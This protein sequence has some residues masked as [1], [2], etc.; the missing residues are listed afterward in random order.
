[1]GS[2]N[3]ERSNKSSTLFCQKKPYFLQF[4]I[5]TRLI[6]IK[7]LRR[8]GHSS[9]LLKFCYDCQQ[10]PGGATA[11][12]RSTSKYNKVH[13]Y[14]HQLKKQAVTILT[15]KNTFLL[16]FSKNYYSRKRKNC[17]QFILF[18][19]F[20]IVSFYEQVNYILCCIYELAI[21]D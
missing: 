17:L 3:N 5:C 18:G 12:Y 16:I 4:S 13:V 11:S 9:K 2:P 14:K 7:Q 21:F 8:S 20:Y 19:F 1:M 15:K 6:N 10:T